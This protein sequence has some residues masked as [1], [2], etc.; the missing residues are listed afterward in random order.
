VA[1][2]LRIVEDG[3]VLYDICD[4]VEQLRKE[5]QELR[6]LLEKVKMGEVK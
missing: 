2:T 3:V 5:N 1:K 6:D 4:E